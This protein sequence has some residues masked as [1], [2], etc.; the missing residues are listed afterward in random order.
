LFT[1]GFNNSFFIR[2]P[3]AIQSDKVRARFRRNY[4]DNVGLG[5]SLSFQYPKDGVLLE[6]VYLQMELSAVVGAGVG[7]YA[8]YCDFVGYAAI[9]ELKLNYTQNNLM[10]LRPTH[11]FTK[12][13]RDY[14][15]NNQEIFDDLV[16][17]NL[18]AA[19]RNTLATATQY[20]RIPLK[21]FW[22]QLPCHTPVITAL[23]QY[24]TVDIDFD[25]KENI[26]QTD[27]TN[28]AAATLNSLTYVYD[29]INF[30]GNDRDQASQPTF[31]PRGQTFLIEETKS[32]DYVKIA[33]GLS[34][35]TYKFTG[36]TAPFSSIYFLLQPMANVTTNYQRKPFELTASDLNLISEYTLKDG[37]L[38]IQKIQ[39]DRG[40]LQEQWQKRHLIG[41]FRKPIGFLSVSEVADIKNQNLGSLNAS[42]IYSSLKHQLFSY[43]GVAYKGP[44]E[45]KHRTIKYK[46]FE[47]VDTSKVMWEDSMSTYILFTHRDPSGNDPVVE[48]EV[49][50]LDQFCKAVDGF[51]VDLLE[52]IE[53][54]NIKQY[55]HLF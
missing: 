29:V 12:H 11:Y 10:I 46:G 40:E 16:K 1:T 49:E 31:G 3:W 8:R 9:K 43:N 35:F 2:R 4:Q 20:P 22:D 19:E 33:S 42:T 13:F 24:L 47:V 53:D 51:C 38:E 27:Y 14:N 7:S 36:F 37:E 55:R 41:K 21:L 45:H 32:Q 54:E 15:L 18:T 30:T 39:V 17:G 44:G 34:E 52:I 48:T 5:R 28:G 50:Y 25:S 23:A 26:V 6:D